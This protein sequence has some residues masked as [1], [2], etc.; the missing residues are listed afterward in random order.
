MTDEQIARIRAALS[1]ALSGIEDN[2]E[3]H[4]ELFNA[5]VAFD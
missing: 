2:D 5:C 4:M 1:A 3:E